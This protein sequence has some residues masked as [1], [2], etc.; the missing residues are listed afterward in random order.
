MDNVADQE[1]RRQTGSDLFHGVGKKTVLVKGEDD[2]WIGA[3]ARVMQGVTVGKGA[4]IGANSLVTRDV[5]PY[6]IAVGSPARLEICENPGLLRDVSCFI[7]FNLVL[8]IQ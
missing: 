6:A 1:F 2:V 4:I 3:G 7:I 8:S 5:P